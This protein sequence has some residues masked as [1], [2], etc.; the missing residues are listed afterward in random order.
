MLQSGDYDRHLRRARL[1]YRRRRDLLVRTL[2]ET[3]LAP[4]V[5][6]AAA[7]LHLV[8][9]L[10]A[11]ISEADAA[12]AAASE[13][14]GVCGLARYRARHAPRAPQG[15]VL[16]YGGFAE[17]RFVPALRRLRKALDAIATR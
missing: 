12:A 14:V 1:V 6:G 7:G 9:S 15:L 11:P 4:T 17:R 10:P 3:R 8:A 5:S 16:G 13:G 2:A